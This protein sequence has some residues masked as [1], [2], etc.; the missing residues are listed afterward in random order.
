MD[1]IELNTDDE[2]VWFQR[3]QCGSLL[4]V[5]LDRPGVAPPGIAAP[6]TKVWG[7]SGLWGREDVSWDPDIGGALYRAPIVYGIAACIAGPA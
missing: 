1:S 4:L 2:P 7:V 5:V 6:T 3:D